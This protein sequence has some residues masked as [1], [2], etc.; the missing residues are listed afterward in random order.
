LV[1]RAR[2]RRGAFA[3]RYGIKEVYDT[4]EDLL[5]REVPDIVSLILPV[6]YTY[7]AVIACAEAGVRVVSC[8]KPIAAELSR[9]DEMV[10]VCRERGTLL[11][12]GQAAWATPYMPDV[13]E[14]VRAGNIGRLTGVAVP[15]GLPTEISGGGCVQLAGIRI[16]TGMEVEWVEGWTLPS[17]P[18]YTAPPGQPE[19]EADCPAF[20][21][22]GL[23]G[24]IVC[25]IVE[26]RSG[27]RVD[28]F[29]SA[30]GEDGQ[31][32]LSRPMP[33]LIQGKGARSTPV[34]PEFLD[35]PQPESFFVPTIERLMRAFDTGEE[36]LSSGDDFRHSLETAIA[37][38]LSSLRNHE[39]VALPL[40]DRSLRLYPYPYRYRGGDEA[41]WAGGGYKG[42]PEVI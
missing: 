32:W 14:W 15:G 33:V 37:I 34:H 2:D 30:E 21:R 20:G 39:R 24:G 1:D 35:A 18:G 29:I 8:E 42:P 3:D 36:P 22:L 4:V 12:C 27:R 7:G 11:G 38:K 28:C 17:E 23:S 26:P 19:A 25:D 10:S 31:V 40:E 13:I 6:A 5:A 41:G 16:L 9:A